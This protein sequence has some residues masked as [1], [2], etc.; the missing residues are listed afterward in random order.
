MASVGLVY[1]PIFLEH[2]LPGHPER[3][4]RLRA[5]LDAL[6]AAGL[7]DRFTPVA[8]EPADEEDLARVHDPGY[9]AR[10]AALHGCRGFLDADTYHA[11]ATVEAALR[12]AGGCAALARGLAAGELSGGLAL[13]RPPGH[14]AERDRAMGFCLI[15]NIAV[16]ASALR[17]GGRRVAI[18]DFDV[19][20]G[21]GTQQAFEA[22]GDALFVSLHRYGGLFYPGTGAASEVGVGGGVGAT[23]NVPLPAGAGTPEY[24]EALTAIVEPA[25]DRFAPELILVSA[26]FDAHLADPLGGMVVDDEGFEA[27]IAR[28][29]SWAARHCE[30]RWLAVLEGGYDLEAVSRGAVTLARALLDERRT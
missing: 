4:E 15:N 29:A 12:A 30:G 24:M 19:H 2:V 14:H 16:A 1:D 18:V 27:M 5:C 26:G 6:H 28:I 20:H 13:V 8:A 17:A 23:L 21:N 7:R 25:I 11:P 9:L 10:L 3:P 22:D